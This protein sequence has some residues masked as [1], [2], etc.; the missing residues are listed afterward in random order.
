MF[1]AGDDVQDVL[2]DD[3]ELGE[4][5]GDEVGDPD[6]RD[7]GEQ[8]A[9]DPVGDEKGD[10]VRVGRAEH[11]QH[12]VGLP[13]HVLV[14]GDDGDERRPDDV[15]PV[16]ERD[17]DGEAAELPGERG[18]HRRDQ[19]AED[20][21]AAEAGTREDDVD[22]DGVAVREGPLV[23]GVVPLVA[24]DALGRVA[25]QV[26]QHPGVGRDDLD[27][28]PARFRDREA[29]DGERRDRLERQIDEQ[30]QRNGASEHE[31]RRPTVVQQV[32]RVRTRRRADEREDRLHVALVLERE[33]RHH[34]QP[35]QPEQPPRAGRERA[36]RRVSPM[37]EHPRGREE[38]RDDPRERERVRED[39]ERRERARCGHTD[40]VGFRRIKPLSLPPTRPGIRACSIRDS[41]S[42]P[43][44]R[45]ESP[46]REGGA[47]SLRSSVARSTRSLRSLPCKTFRA[48]CSGGLPGCDLLAPVRFAHGNVVGSALAT[49]PFSPPDRTATAP[50]ASP[51]SS[52][53]SLATPS[54]ALAR[55]FAARVRGLPPV[56]LA[57]RARRALTGAPK[58]SAWCE[59]VENHLGVTW[60]RRP[61]RPRV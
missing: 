16:D 25:E 56:A 9:E 50:H 39:G 26:D 53:A 38:E 27:E 41:C 19:A 28:D 1:L 45:L 6:Q 30:H 36:P 22:P 35:E 52:L 48:A 47:D 40:S 11:R 17:R 51:A 2:Q 34:R 29:R 21:H 13:V 14:A 46:S 42:D 37:V 44:D 3:D 57:T 8:L 54:R 10:P 18:V 61:R 7:D 33:V 15:E 31:Q 20:R 4:L 60:S 23:G 55:G 24:G 49:A 12:E 5:S 59:S 43:H 32:A 58:R